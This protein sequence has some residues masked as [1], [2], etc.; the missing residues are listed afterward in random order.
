MQLYKY[1]G[2]DMTGQRVEGEMSGATIE[3]VE[4]KI[5]AQAVTIIA[6][7]PAGSSKR[8]AAAAAGGAPSKA[9]MLGF[10]PKKLN[11]NDLSAILNDLA[12]MAETGVPFVEA[13]EAVMLTARTPAISAGLRDLRAEV[14]GGKSL[15]AAMKSSAIFPTIVSD[16]VKV[17]EEGGRLDRALH[18]AAVYVQRAADLKK[19][20]M[21]AML[22]PIVLSVIAFATLAVMIT[23]VLPRFAKIFENMKAE[24]PGI[25]KFLLSLGESV[26]GQPILWVGG[27]VGVIMVV[28]V[29]WTM[30]TSYRMISKFLLRVPVLGELLRRLALS[31][32]CQSIATLLGS[33]VPLMSALE[34]G[35]KVAGNPIITEALMKARSGVE[36]GASLSE[37]M[38]E[39]RAF[40]PTLIQMVS[41]GERTGRLGMLMATT[42]SNME[43]D[44]DGRL[45]ALISIVEPVMIV[46]MGSIVGVITLS[47][48]I[49]MYSIVENIK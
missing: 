42:A 5:T 17:A 38:R 4:R 7:M 23:F 27:I 24:L 2:Y 19:K 31:R 15:S 48:I 44:V 35:A 28:K 45:K 10:G 32:A 30:P 8:G 34:H 37:S 39:T 16:M 49:P 18:S 1:K 26:K 47:I 41:V 40:P 33:N 14:V 29:A 9:S 3:E 22:Y 13:L 25:T 43:S 20:V 36:H 21:N 12:I 46:V 11:D 6:I